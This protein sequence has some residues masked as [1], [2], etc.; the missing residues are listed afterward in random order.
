VVEDD[1]AAGFGCSIAARHSHRAPLAP[2]YLV[3][4]TA[5]LPAEGGGREAVAVARYLDDRIDWAGGRAAS[6]M[7]IRT[8]AIETSDF[9]DQR[10]DVAVDDDDVFWIGSAQTSRTDLP[11]PIVLL[12]EGSRSFSG[13]E[14]IE[15]EL[16]PLDD[17]RVYRLR[18]AA[19]GA[20]ELAVAFLDADY[21]PRIA[22]R[23]PDEAGPILAELVAPAD[24]T[25]R[26]YNRDESEPPAREADRD[27]QVRNAANIASYDGG[28]VGMPLDVAFSSRLERP[29]V[30]WTAYRPNGIDYHAVILAR[31]AN[32]GG[33]GASS[34]LYDLEAID[35]RIMAAGS[36]TLATSVSGMAR[37]AFH[38]GI[39]QPFFPATPLRA[40]DPQP[41]YGAGRL[42]FYREEDEDEISR[43]PSHVRR[44]AARCVA[45]RLFV[46]DEP[47]LDSPR[48]GLDDAFAVLQ[49]RPA[50]DFDPCGRTTDPGLDVALTESIYRLLG[51]GSPITGDPD[52]LTPY[53]AQARFA[54]RP[55][56]DDDTYI[57]RTND[58][59]RAELS[60]LRNVL[61]DL[62]VLD[63][64]PLLARADG[65]SWDVFDEN[66]APEASDEFFAQAWNPAD[67]GDE[68][69][70]VQG[71]RLDP[72][73]LALDELTEDVC[74]NYDA[75]PACADAAGTT[76]VATRDREHC[77]NPGVL[78]R[79]P[80]P[81]F[82][83]LFYGG[84]VD[85]P[86]LAP[87]DRRSY[88]SFRASYAPSF[89]NDDAMGQDLSDF[90]QP[91]LLRDA[92]VGLGVGGA[93][94]TREGDHV[95][96]PI[97]GCPSP[98]RS[99]VAL[100]VP[101]GLIG[102]FPA[103][104]VGTS[105]DAPPVGACAPRRTGAALRAQPDTNGDG[106]PDLP[107]L[108]TVAAVTAL[109]QPTMIATG[110]DG[111]ACCEGYGP[112]VCTT[113]A[114]CA[115]EQSD[116]EVP[117]GGTVPVCRSGLFS[118]RADNSCSLD[119][120]DGDGEPDDCDACVSGVCHTREVPGGPLVP[121][122]QATACSEGRTGSC[123]DGNCGFGG[124]DCTNC[125]LDCGGACN[126]YCDD[127]ASD[128]P[129]Y[130][131]EICGSDAACLAA[132]TGALPDYVFSQVNTAGRAMACGSGTSC[133]ATD[134]E[135]V[136][137]AYL[138][139]LFGHYLLNLL[140]PV[141]GGSLG[142]VGRTVEAIAGAFRF[143]GGIELDET[144]AEARVRW[145][146]HA[147]GALGLQGYYEITLRF[148][149]PSVSLGYTGVTLA[150][151]SPARIRIRI[152]PYF[153]PQ[154]SISACDA[155][156]R[157]APDPS[158]SWVVTEAVMIRDDEGS[159]EPPTVGGCGGCDGCDPGV[160]CLLN[161]CV[162]DGT[163]SIE[164]IDELPVEARLRIER[165]LQRTLANLDSLLSTILLE[166]VVGG[167]VLGRA[168][169]VAAIR[170]APSCGP[171]RV[172][173]SPAP[174]CDGTITP[175]I[176]TTSV[177]DTIELIRI[178]DGL[179]GVVGRDNR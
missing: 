55:G 124:E 114:D 17:L 97:G 104:A 66:A 1:G 174:E 89:A 98:I 52:G 151:T 91:G 176:R 88:T 50:F 108:T 29:L 172:P 99:F 20:G 65:S 150:T 7:N 148:E 56:E 110:V 68:S 117:E 107:P 10:L 69:N 165:A 83:G 6:P 173:A 111:F 158:V 143:D 129:A 41:F 146:S 171:S 24:S 100:P 46:Q 130:A 44:G 5:L 19:R 54:R 26:G 178:G 21:R 123:G 3:A 157:R 18:L 149:D 93:G 78:E 140:R 109:T 135:N 47:E 8:A 76:S 154:L 73:F 57:D 127:E 120:G 155:C 119:D 63:R 79:N 36:L 115:R 45:P 11:A 163:L 133:R 139:P 49:P 23:R 177:A 58:I 43:A 70:P 22:H 12:G 40:F 161:T 38:N 169:A 67:I 116:C 90:E 9:I 60:W 64:V 153:R 80:N 92:L 121:V 81:F 162:P 141:V 39:V 74:G 156:A 106:F 75:G 14:R 30:A 94:L 62:R 87:A 2:D 28:L 131:A 125:P 167:V 147:D 33:G 4:Y 160:N 34:N 128:A 175:S 13:G 95:C 84:T 53:R 35:G 122:C 32:V 77:V 136:P 25:I 164:D 59:R 102:L 85:A 71:G 51:P 166:P 168:N 137:A 15:V 42:A 113:S 82:D 179:A 159:T 134:G 61:A 48:A 145:V 142:A 72:L 144:I 132:S 101:S 96:S 37:I 138:R 16:P 170:D 118:A 86:P 152:Q 31:P 126:S 105:P 27:H 103:T 112:V